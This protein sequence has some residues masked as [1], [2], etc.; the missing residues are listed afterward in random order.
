MFSTRQALESVLTARDAKDIYDVIA[1]SE[2][3]LTKMK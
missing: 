3:R 1:A 2:R